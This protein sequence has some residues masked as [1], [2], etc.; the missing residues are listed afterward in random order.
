M[1]KIVFL[2]VLCIFSYTAE[3]Q[4]WRLKLKSNVQ[5]RT[6]KLTSKSEVEEKGLAGASIALYKG[7]SKLSEVLSD[8][9]GDFMVE[10]PP[11]GEFTLVVSYPGCNTKKFAVSTLGVPE[12]MNKDEK[13]KPSFGIGGFIMARAFPG[14]DYSTLKQP[15]VKV[16]YVPKLKNFNDDK[17][18]TSQMLNQIGAISDAEN[19]LID[20]FTSTNKI[21]DDALRRGD[22]PLAK[23][24]YE[25]AMTIIPGEIYPKDQLEKVG[26]C[27]KEKEDA[28]K[29]AADDAAAK[30]AAQKSA[31]EKAAADK[32]AAEQAAK[33]KAEADK[34]AR[35][36]LAAENAAKQKE[37]EK[38]AAD[39]ALADKEAADKAAKEKET[40]EALAKEKL[41]LEKAA[42]QKEKDDKKAAAD[43][44]AREKAEADKLAKEKQAAA[45]AEKNNTTT[46][47][48]KD[49]GI[50]PSGFET[51]ANTEN[52]NGNKG[53]S[54]YKTPQVLGANPYKD[55]ITKAD[56]FLKMKRYSE[57][58][59]AYEEALKAKPD[60]PYATKKL[61][62][63]ISAL[64][65]K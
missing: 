28:A 44:A 22:C 34:A 1:K 63:V 20:Q 57:A 65:P 29:K 49:N 18:Y 51:P 14:I 11:N 3:A 8:A 48:P 62:E 55:A 9:N 27:L 46:T 56:G 13:F 26:L 35:E 64:G 42:K 17:D 45:A 23:A 61:A 40:A 2:L 31:E 38:A 6:W 41:A 36:K 60:D 10:V 50:K 12:E 32:L 19:V 54:K 53:D 39:K 43:K 33:D 4:D 24:S 5:L 37:K 52:S 30:A 58:K 59:A 47:P 16:V 15:L 21:G 25:K 7:A